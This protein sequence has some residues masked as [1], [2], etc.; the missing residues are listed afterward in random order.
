MTSTNPLASIRRPVRAVE[1][2]GGSTVHVRDLT[3]AEIGAIDDRTDT[4]PIAKLP[5]GETEKR[6]RRACLYVAFV[7]ANPDGS[8]MF[9]AVE[10]RDL[11]AIEAE[12][13]PSQIEAIAAAGPTKDAAKNG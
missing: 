11:E 13:T 1:L 5:L 8:P 9:G 4:P 12:L 10:E 6:V 3:L 7:L 2:P